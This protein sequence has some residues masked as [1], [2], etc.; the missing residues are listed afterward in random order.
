MYT[1]VVVKTSKQN[2]WRPCRY[3]DLQETPYTFKFL[4]IK[5]KIYKFEEPS[6]FKQSYNLKCFPS[7]VSP[8]FLN[9][10]NLQC[11]KLED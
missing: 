9:V 11:Q 8:F 6:I 1:C 7:T 5:F 10:A 4:K 2:L 3:G